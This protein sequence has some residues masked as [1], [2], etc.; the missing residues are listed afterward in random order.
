MPLPAP[1][2]ELRERMDAMESSWH[3]ASRLADER[4]TDAVRRAMR[5]AQQEEASRREAQQE[6]WDP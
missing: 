3:E 5:E 2:D 6:S 4:V 1:L